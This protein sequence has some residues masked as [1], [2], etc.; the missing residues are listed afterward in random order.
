MKD[1]AEAMHAGAKWLEWE[2]VEPF[3]PAGRGPVT[4]A[5]WVGP[6]L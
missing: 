6:V 1:Q 2:Y 5:A 3:G 4:S